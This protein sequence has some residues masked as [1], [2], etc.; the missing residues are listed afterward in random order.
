VSLSEWRAGARKT[1][2]VTEPTGITR[3]DG[4]GLTMRLRGRPD[5]P[6][7]FAIPKFAFEIDLGKLF[8]A[9]RTATKRNLSR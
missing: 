9:T 5:L 7:I 4:E 8:D 3:V 2:Y 1:R 6:P